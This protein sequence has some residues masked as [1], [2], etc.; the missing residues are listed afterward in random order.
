MLLFYYFDHLV[1]IMITNRSLEGYQ[2]YQSRRISHWDQVARS[3][4]TWKGWGT[5][6]HR[7]LARIYSHSIPA[8]QRILE[9]GCGDGSLLA[10]L[11][12]AKGVGIDFS[13]EMCRRAQKNHPELEIILG[14]AHYL[15]LKDEFDFIILSDLIN[16][17]WDVQA[18]FHQIARLAVKGTK[19]VINSY[20]KLWEIPLYL[21]QILKLAKPNL[22][23]NWLSPQDIIHIFE[24]EDFEAIKITPEIIFPINVPFLSGLLNR[25]LGRVWPFK[26]LSITN[27]IIARSI[28]DQKSDSVYSVSVVIPARNEEG[29]IEG[30]FKRTPELGRG[31]ELIFV[32]GHSLD[33]TYQKIQDCLKTYSHRNVKLLQQTG[34]GKGD[35]VRLGFEQA[36][37]DILMI[38][39]A[40]LSVPPEDL[41]LFYNAL[42]AGKGQ[43]ING[44]RLI[45][46]M[47]DQAMRYLNLLGNKFFSM[48]FSW[49]LGQPVKDTLCG[50]KVL[51]KNDYRRIAENRTYFG[52]FDP[53][54]DFD[55]LF[56]AAKQNLKII[57]LPIRYRQRTY[58]QTNIQRFRHGFLLL[59]MVFIAALKLK[60]I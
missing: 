40:D 20:S 49:L 48:T 37:G 41:S 16:D 12:P 55:L 7:Q 29:N 24:L 4:D 43:F 21:G 35:A 59:R 39:D 2:T 52:D 26:H 14:D 34:K 42:A 47:E 31:T 22:P 51:F 13:A 38:L 25:F 50:T 45:Y 60:F 30:L 5:H 44:V 19:I 9:I 18:I 56:G 36:E 23:Q 54:G 58:G 6:Y 11:S 15:P 28:K 8:N 32:E 27:L 53:F 33:K 46:P 3:L 57:D 17:V 1:K 10:A